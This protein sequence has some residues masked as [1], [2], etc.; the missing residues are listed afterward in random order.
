MKKV[1][2]ISGQVAYLHIKLKVLNNANNQT[3]KENSHFME[4]LGQF[5]ILEEKLLDEVM[6]TQS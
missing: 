6:A 2:N 5:E 3:Q 1:K 4:H